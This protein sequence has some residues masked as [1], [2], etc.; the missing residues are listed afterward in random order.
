MLCLLAHYGHHLHRTYTALILSTSI[1]C[2][3]RKYV[4]NFTCLSCLLQHNKWSHSVSNK[5]AE[6]S[7]AVGNSRSKMIRSKSPKRALL[8]R[9]FICS[10]LTYIENPPCL[11]FFVW[12]RSECL[13]RC[14]WNLGLMT[15]ALSPQPAP[16][17]V[18]GC[19]SDGGTYESSAYFG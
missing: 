6:Q 7:C 16:G 18:W 13:V 4:M 14:P 17:I 1:T 15:Y 5:I 2:I 19:S 8:V 9:S 12:A 10:L 11:R 3:S